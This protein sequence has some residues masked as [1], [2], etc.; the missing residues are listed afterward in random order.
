LHG[1]RLGT[2]FMRHLRFDRKLGGGLSG[3]PRPRDRRRAGDGHD[4]RR[5]EKSAHDGAGFAS[6]DTQNRPYV[7]A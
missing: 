6:V 4:A 1:G 7:D 3:D 2:A 5:A